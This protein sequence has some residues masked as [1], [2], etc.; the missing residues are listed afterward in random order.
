[1]AEQMQ[2]PKIDVRAA[3]RAAANYLQSIQDLIPAENLRLEEVEISEDQNFWLITLGFN[4]AKKEQPNLNNSLFMA[5]ITPN[6][7]RQYKIFRV[8]SHTGEVE[9]MKIRNL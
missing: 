3:V 9:A 6:E 1:M 4:E 2:T 8:N 5:G 7:T